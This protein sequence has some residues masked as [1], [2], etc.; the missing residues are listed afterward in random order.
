MAQRVLKDPFKKVHEM[1]QGLIEDLL[2][3]ENKEAEKKSF[4]DTETNRSKKDRDFR[5]VEIEKLDA[6]LESLEAKKDELSQAI[7]DFDKGIA[8]GKSDLEKATDERDDNNKMNM[9]TLETAK[10]GHE[11]I[12]EALHILR[13]FYKEAAKAK[14]ALLQRKEP[15]ASGENYAGNQEEGG[16]IIEVLEDV[17]DNFRRT[18][19][20]TENDEKEA[21]AE[22]VKF[23]A[24]TLSNIESKK[25]GKKLSEQDL[26][27]TKNKIE[28][29]TD[30][31]KSAKKMM[32]IAEAEIEDLKPECDDL[33]KTYEERKVKRREEVSALMLAQCFLDPARKEGECTKENI[34]K[35]RRVDK[36]EGLKEE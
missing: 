16:N 2:Q 23:K 28:S 33:Q 31:K 8:E 1:I 29:K 11:A 17:R 24:T 25:L 15:T 32:E 21:A 13:S 12:K 26:E 3:E 18:I 30:D 6:L 4:C 20:E 36:K 27:K 34:E 19:S 10:G 22:F 5:K 7:D 35:E 9:E 14:P